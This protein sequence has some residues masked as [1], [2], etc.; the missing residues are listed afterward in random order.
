MTFV[1]G[2]SGNPAGKPP[3][4]IGEKTKERLNRARRML[5]IIESRKDFE[6]LLDHLKPRELITLWKDLVEYDAPKLART[7]ICDPEGNA[8]TINVRLQSDGSEEV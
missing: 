5:E 6:K 1:K 4:I 3:G 8:V 7:E 2:Q